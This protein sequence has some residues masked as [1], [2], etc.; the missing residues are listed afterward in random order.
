MYLNLKKKKKN[1]KLAKCFLTT[2][3]KAEQKLNTMT[4]TEVEAAR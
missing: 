2:T 1:K 4:K 3:Y